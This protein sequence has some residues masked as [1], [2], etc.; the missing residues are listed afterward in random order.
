MQCMAKQ[1]V[2]V[3]L[4][5]RLLLLLLLHLAAAQRTQLTRA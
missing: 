1:D 2:R 4:L 3:L 5:S